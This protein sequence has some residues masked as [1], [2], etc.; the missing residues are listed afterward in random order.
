[1]TKNIQLSAHE[2]IPTE[3]D[4]REWSRM[5]NAAYGSDHNDIGHRYSMAAASTRIG[6][7][8]PV[9]RFD[10]LQQGYRAWLIDNIFPTL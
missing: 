5:A 3:H 2:I 1:M 7:S 9:A 8:M 10:A 6:E 4:K